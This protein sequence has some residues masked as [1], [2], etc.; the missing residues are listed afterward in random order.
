M[1]TLMNEMELEM[2]IGGARVYGTKHYL[3]LRKKA[4]Y[5]D[6][7][8]IGRLYNGEQVTVLKKGIRNGNYTYTLVYSPKL[9]RCGYVVAGYLR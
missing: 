1:R 8:E 6:K 3:A 2:V 4:A 9:H 7:T 5:S